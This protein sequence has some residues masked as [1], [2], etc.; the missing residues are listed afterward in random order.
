LIT[1]RLVGSSIRNQAW[2]TLDRGSV[3]AGSLTGE[4]CG[5]GGPGESKDQKDQRDFKDSLLVLW[6]LEVLDVPLLALRVRVLQ[7]AGGMDGA[8]L[9][10]P[11]RGEIWG[12][13]RLEQH[14]ERLAARQMARTGR[15]RGRE[16]AARLEDNGRVL[17]GAYRKI[18]EVMR[19]ERVTTPA[20]E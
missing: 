7:E 2:S 1:I 14:A 4:H 8:H 18:A 15:S 19:S 6:V 12:V 16:L 11:I 20:A 10:E 9:P 17:L 13:E 3:I 5:A